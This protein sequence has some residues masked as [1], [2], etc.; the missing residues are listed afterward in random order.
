VKKYIAAVL[1][2]VC[3]TAA[4]AAYDTVELADGGSYIPAAPAR[5]AAVRALSTVAAGTVAVK[6]VSTLAVPTNTAVVTYATNYTYTAIW[7]NGTETVTNTTVHEQLPLGSNVTSYATNTIVTATTNW[8]PGTAATV[9]A[10][11]TLVSFTC[12][13]GAGEAVPTNAFLLPGETVF[14]DGTASGRVLLVIEE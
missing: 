6:S 5:V 12:S 14:F 13:G 10:T 7:T 4:L 11:N 2:A 8:V 1:A 9:A 3:A